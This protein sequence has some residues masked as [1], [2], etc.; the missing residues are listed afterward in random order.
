MKD[1]SHVGKR[2]G[3][4]GT[5]KVSAIGVMVAVGLAFC[6]V[7]AP[8]S[9][10]LLVTLVVGVFLGV[11]LTTL[12][13]DWYQ[14]GSDEVDVDPSS[15]LYMGLRRLNGIVTRIRPKRFIRMV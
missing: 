13:V 6:M 15:V 8:V 11:L 4:S 10:G 14:S 2:F 1:Y 9:D 12:V 5:I 7:S 3:N